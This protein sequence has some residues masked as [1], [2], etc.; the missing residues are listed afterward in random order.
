GG[1]AKPAGLEIIA[2]LKV[3][4]IRWPATTTKPTDLGD[5]TV[6]LNVYKGRVVIY[7]PMAVPPDAKPGKRMIKIFPLGQLCGK[8]S[9][10]DFQPLTGEK[11]FSVAATVMVGDKSVVNPAWAKAGFSQEQAQAAVTDS[12]PD[13]GE[14]EVGF[15]LAVGIALLA[16]L[17]LNVMPCVLPV[18]PIRI[19]S[20]VDMAGGSRRRFVTMGMAFAGGVMFFFAGIAT[21]NIILKL[22]V[23]RAVDINEAFV[24]PVVI[25]FLAM[26]VVALAANLFGVFHFIVPTRIASMENH[27][28]NGRGGH[29]KS[30]GMGLMMAILATPCSFAFLATA[31]TYAQT[32]PLLNGTLVILAVGLGMSGP[33]A[34]LAAFPSLVDKLPRPGVWMEWFKQASGFLLLVVAV[35]LIASLRGDGSSYPF[36]VIAWGVV[37]VMS[38]WIWA[39][40]V[41]YDAPLAKK[42]LVRGLAV[43]LAVGTGLWMLPRAEPPMT[44]AQPFDAAAVLAA[45][46]AGRIVVV[47]FTSNTCIKCIQQDANVY[48]TPEIAK[49]FKAENIAY[50][51]GNISASSAAVEWMRANGFGTAVP[52]TLV[53]PA[54]GGKFQAAVALDIPKL[55]AMLDEAGGVK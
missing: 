31:L 41:R 55:N 54:G 49:R 22:T 27:V 29:C 32:A 17:V 53:Y 28:Q 47:K 9:C 5:R 25:I 8:N 21:L 43:A 3:G 46:K 13:S 33:H 7:V 10:V 37:L 12:Q 36:W 42:L 24:N 45:Q 38:L 48:N 16:G 20:V 14:D 35:W 1:P 4:A 6:N 15:W 39:N 52:L 34:L 18:I 44:K 19:L 40:W 51:K 23:G 11:N 2:D 26:I 30:A 50:F